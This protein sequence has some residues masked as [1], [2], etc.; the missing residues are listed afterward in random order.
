MVREKNQKKKKTIRK[1]L[2][3]ETKK[4]KDTNAFTDKTDTDYQT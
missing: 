1:H 4:K 2:K 3:T